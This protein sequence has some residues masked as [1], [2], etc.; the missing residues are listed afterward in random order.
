MHSFPLNLIKS[1]GYDEINFNVIKTCFG[2]LHKPLLHI[3]SHSLQ[4][5]IF[6]DKLKIARVTPLFKKGS[7]SEL[8]NYRLISVLPCFSRIL[9]KIMYNR[10]CKH[11]KEK[12]ILYKKQ[13]GFQ[14]KHST[15]YDILQLIDQVNNRFERNQFTLGISIDLSRA[16]DTVDHKILISKSK[17]YGVRGN[18]LKWFES[19]L[20]NHKQ[21]IAY[22]N[23]YASFETI[24]SGVPQGSI[25]APLLF[26]I[27]VNNLNQVSN[28][29]DPIMF[30][31]DTIFFYSH[32]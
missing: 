6:P 20:N 30:A 21:F 29:L 9:E 4:S 15:E 5:G 2:S 26:L 23:K 12:D 27:Y 18:N 3:F 22:S 32:Y 7:D 25:L 19:Y 16:F 1:P 28:I 14:Q 17:N 11:L 24:T 13:F 10:I 31:D 8:G